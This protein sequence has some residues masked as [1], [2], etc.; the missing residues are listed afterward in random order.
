VLIANDLDPAETVFID[1]VPE[2]LTAA[3]RLGMHGVLFG[4]AADLARRLA[5]LPWTA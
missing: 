1:D 3:A 4:G 5:D 2:Y